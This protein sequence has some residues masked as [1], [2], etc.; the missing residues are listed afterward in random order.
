M[1]EKKYKIQRF[2][3][4]TASGLIDR[5][6]D[7]ITDGHR[8]G[9]ACCTKTAD[10]FELLY[11]FDKD[12]ELLNLKLL[13]EEGQEVSSLSGVCWHAFIYEN[14]I[15]DLFGITFKHLELDYGGH[16]FKIAEQT[17]WNPKKQEGETE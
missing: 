6:Q 1:C 8:L 9:Q 3:P 12:Y 5:A 7:L 11:S 16:F 4:V 10:G 13:V 14:E 15:H 17:P 2:E